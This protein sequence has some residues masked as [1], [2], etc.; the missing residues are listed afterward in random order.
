MKTYTV[1]NLD[2]VEG[3]TLNHLRSD[4]EP[5]SDSPT[6]DYQPAENAIAATGADIRFGGDRAFYSLSGDYIQCP[7]R[8]SFEGINEYYQTL[9]HELVHWTEHESRLNWSR[10]N[11]ENTYALGEL[12]AEIGGCYL[13]QE[14]GVPQSDDLA[15]HAAYLDHWLQAMRGDSRFIFQAS[16]QASRGADY[17]LSFSRQ[18]EPEQEPEAALSE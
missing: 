18:T 8:S 6:I 3:D 14:L 17:I 2:Q 5:E 11:T 10:K 16:A 1:F 9:C 15:N 12:I 4:H 13:A 7:S